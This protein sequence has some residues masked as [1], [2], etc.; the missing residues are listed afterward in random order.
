MFY[1]SLTLIKFTLFISDFLFLMHYIYLTF[2]I[3]NSDKSN[4]MDKDAE[5]PNSVV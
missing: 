3:T 5:D 1:L 4:I 2:I